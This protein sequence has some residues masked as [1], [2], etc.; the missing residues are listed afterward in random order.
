MMISGYPARVCYDEGFVWARRRRRAAEVILVH[1]AERKE[2]LQRQ[3]KK[4]QPCSWSNSCAKPAHGPLAKSASVMPATWQ[5]LILIASFFGLW[6]LAGLRTVPDAG[7]R[8]GRSR[9]DHAEN[10]GWNSL[11][12]GS[13]N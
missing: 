13:P 5:S 4:R 6:T 11:P 12:T 8:C 10:R 1:M 2:H 7:C 9:R 3:R